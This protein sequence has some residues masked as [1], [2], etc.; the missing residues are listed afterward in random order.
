MKMTNLEEQIC[1]NDAPQIP[2]L[3]FRRFQGVVDYPQMVKIVE[4]CMRADGIDHS[5][6]LEEV[7]NQYDHL[8]NCDPY[9]DMVF[10]EI[11]GEIVGYSRVFWEKLSEGIRVYNLFGNLHPKWRRKGIGRAMLVYNEGRLRQIAEG[12][13]QDGPR[14]YQSWAADS[15]KGTHA[16]LKNH[17]YKP[18]R[19]GFEMVR[20]LSEPFPEA[21]LPE[22]LEI[23]PVEEDH[24]WQIFH[25]ADEAFKDHWG[26]RPTP[27]EE[28]EGWMKDPNFRPE[29][30]KVAWDGDQVA[31]SV[32][33][34]YNPKENE[35]YQRKRGYTEGISTR[36]PWRRRGL[37]SAL[38]VESMKMFKEMGMTETAHGVDAENTSGA[39][40]LYKKLGY[41]VKKEHTTYR[42]PLENPK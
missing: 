42:K 28:F 5:T 17:D 20:D 25:A 21:P 40:N 32:Q 15:E 39:L 22:G 24:I 3:V 30:W 13:P 8:Q 23:R 37:A 12:H 18:V 36:R 41:K 4:T 14:F 16:L 35:E 33:N 27:D 29:L 6:S 26:Y 19:F 7:A 34:F 11:D 2:G 1:L 38:I 31:G 10:A 9:Q